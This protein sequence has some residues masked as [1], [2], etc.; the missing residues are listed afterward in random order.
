MDVRGLMRQAARFN[1]HRP[2]VVHR[3]RRLTFGEAWERAVRLAN[4]L[5]ALGLEPGDR[6]GV[7]EDNALGAQDVFAGAAAAG[8]VRVPLY[9]RNAPASHRHMLDHTG[10]RA[11]IVSEQHLADVADVAEDLR[12]VEHVLVR[13]DGYE[14]WLAA[15]SA[16]DPDVEIDPD[17]W[18]VIRH[19]G[20]TTGRSKGVAYTHRSWL[21]AGR[22]WFYNFPPM[23]AGEACLHVGPISHGSGYLYTPTWL[24]G[25]VNVLLERF[26]VEE[27]LDVMERERIAYMFMVPAMLNATARH[28]TAA[29]RD[30]SALKV[31]QIGGAP[32][33]D[34]TALI[35]RDVFGE[36][37]YQG[38]GQTEALPV[39][40]MGPQEWF[41]E[42]DGSSPLRS[43]G[44]A[45]PFAYLQIRD[46]EDP[47]RE[48]PIGEEGEIAIRC[49][50]QML[51]FWEDEDATGERMTADGFVLTGD[52]GRLD[53]NAYLYVLDRKDDMI[54]SG[55]FNIWP[56]EL[57]NALLSHPSVVEAAVFAVPDERWG[58]TPVALCVVDDGAEVTEA[59][60]ID[61]CA[62]QLGSYKKPS[63]VELRTEPLPKS[64]VGKIQRKVLRE[65][66]WP[67]DGRRVAGN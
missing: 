44:R 24:S 30:W 8:L 65:P 34:D 16:D 10:C 39:C 60:L 25:G 28:P 56:A 35:G 4:G 50:G 12:G 66:Y 1:E 2:A 27:T 17:D 42:V 26:D 6:V 59:E 3:D 20:G 31:I 5:L 32:I 7:L 37:L 13:D 21:A 63:R 38:Y 19:T 52:I 11:L 48:L 22:D 51:G 40:M 41:S 58:E 23:Q 67:S 53:D 15:Q 64:P 57:E 47:A 9:A 43:A 49:D 54:I 55:G 14:G 18:Y 46:P 61:R 36:V 29:D 45:L 62:E 33:A